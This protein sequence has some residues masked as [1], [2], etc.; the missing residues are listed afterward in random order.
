MEETYYEVRTF[1]NNRP[2][3]IFPTQFASKDEAIE[4]ATAL[5]SL[6]PGVI[7]EHRIYKV[8]ETPINID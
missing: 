5:K 1:K 8:T 3:G 6:D 4:F 7:F 2:S